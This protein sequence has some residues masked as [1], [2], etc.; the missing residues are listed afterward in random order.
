MASPELQVQKLVHT[1]EQGFLARVVRGLLTLLFLGALAGG[2]LFFHFRGLSTQ[3]GIDQAQV[4]R[5][6]A[7]GHGFS[8]LNYRPL[9]IR[10]FQKLT[11]G[12]LPEHLPEIYHA[13][14]QPLVNAAALTAAKKYLSGGAD[15]NHPVYNGDRVI[16]ATAIFFFFAA[17][18]LM[19]GLALRLFDRRIALSV[20]LFILVADQFWQFALSGLP[21]MLLLFLFALALHCLDWAIR[22][23]LRG[24]RPYASLA[25]LGLILGLMALTQPLTLFIAGGAVLFCVI[26]FQPRLYALL[27]P[28]ALCLAV[29]SLWL[30]HNYR[31]S[32][33]PFGLAPFAFVHDVGGSSLAWMRRPVP[34]FSALNLSALRQRVLGSLV[35]QLQGLTTLLGGVL[36]APL[37]FLALLHRFKRPETEAF[38]WALGLMW[39]ATFLGTVLSGMESRWLD[40]NQLHLLFGP[41]MSLYGLAFTLVTLSRLYAEARSVRVL[42]IVA[43]GLITA[44]PAALGLLAGGP[45]VNFPPYLPGLMRSFNAWTQPAEVIVS[46]MPWAVSWYGDRKSI[47]LPDKPSTYNE[48]ADYQTI[49]PIV[50][51][52]LTPVSRDLKYVSQIGSGEYSDWAGLLVGYDKAL[53]AFPLHAHVSLVDN[54]C[55]LLADRPR[56]QETAN[57]DTK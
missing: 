47:L 10:Y 42:L 6:L 45:P 33:S 53:E 9:Q 13:P 25:L 21:Q 40:P 31:V 29:F 51:L 43:I 39:L 22:A 17:V 41:A 7:A 15:G 54:Q 12:L 38:K 28:G 24:E 57:P 50:I 44:V 36:V 49:G 18:A 46:D 52:Y 1:V 55:L 20:A 8:T 4:A 23:N 19:Y 48:Y 27:V 26:H 32:H 11:D 34:D 30:W 16:A 35:A 2:Y 14:L 3:D 37:F 5:E 56:W